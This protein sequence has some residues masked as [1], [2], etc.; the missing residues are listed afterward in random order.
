MDPPPVA[1]P[2]GRQAWGMTNEKSEGFEVDDEAV[3]DVGL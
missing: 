3:A 2:A 1:L